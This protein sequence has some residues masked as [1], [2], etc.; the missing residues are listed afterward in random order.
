MRASLLGATLVASAVGLGGQARPNGGGSG[1]FAAG[2]GAAAAATA[3]V[4]A[5]LNNDHIINLD[6]IAHKSRPGISP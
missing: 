4:V 3:E 1:G 6:I 5:S 2:A